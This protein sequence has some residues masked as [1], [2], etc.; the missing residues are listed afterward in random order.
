MN[1][2][3]TQETALFAN[4]MVFPEAILDARPIPNSNR[5]LGTFAKHNSTPRGSLAIV[6]PRLGKNALEAINNL[7]HPD[8]ATF[9]R[10]DSC[11]PW[12]VSEDVLIFSGRR[13]GQERNVIEIMNL[14]GT[15]EVLL[16]D[17]DICLHSPMLIK[18]R[19][20]PRIL[21][22]TVDRQA[23]TG[24]FYVQDIYRGLSGVER[25]E[26]KWL[27]VIEE[28][29]RVSASPGGTNPYNQTFLVSCAWRSA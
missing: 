26:V 22:D 24:R 16:S 23:R 15:R 4:N 13:P 18:P 10:G 2:D 29:S 27:R 14:G 20:L 12:A 11:E 7:E 3:G 6:D 17:P 25:G 19:P 1:P 28:T 5:I 9:D 21:P 8:D